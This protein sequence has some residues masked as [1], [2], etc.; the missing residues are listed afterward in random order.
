VQ[1]KVYLDAILTVVDAKHAL[2][3]LG[4]QKPEGVENEARSPQAGLCAARVSRLGR[5]LASQP[6]CADAGRPPAS[7]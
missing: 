5:R 6:V 7:L 2:P 3:H 4:E 1:A